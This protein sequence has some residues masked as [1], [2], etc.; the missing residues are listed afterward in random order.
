MNMGSGKD[1]RD[2]LFEAGISIDD[3][4]Y[5]AL[6]LYVPHPGV[7]NRERADEVFRR[8]LDIALS[9]PNLALLIYAGV[10]LEEEGK[11]A[12][13]PN[14]KSSDYERDLTYLIAD[15]V[16]GMTIAKYVGGYKG[17]FD[18]VRYDKAKPGILGELGPFMDDVIAGLIGGV[19]ANMYTRAVFD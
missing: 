2:V 1:I 19:C 18:Y 14:M 12:S 11:R 6:E 7:E 13:L 3:V 15:E 16:I 5:A 9:D 4:V 10:L 8:E 17:T